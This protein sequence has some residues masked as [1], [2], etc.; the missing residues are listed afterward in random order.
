MKKIK[1]RVLL[2]QNCQ[3]IMFDHWFK[4]VRSKTKA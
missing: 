1:A 3:I 4:Q 2:T